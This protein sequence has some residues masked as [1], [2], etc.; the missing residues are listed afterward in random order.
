MIPGCI[1]AQCRRQEAW[2]TV[3]LALIR[4]LVPHDQGSS[5]GFL[6]LANARRVTP[7]SNPDRGFPSLLILPSALGV[8]ACFRYGCFASLLGKILFSVVPPS[9]ELRLNH[10]GDGPDEADQLAR[11]RHDHLG[12][13]FAGRREP[14]VSR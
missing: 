14:A 8:E 2:T 10:P 11:D 7:A 3:D 9:G 1:G 12:G 4:G 13:R 5:W 6:C